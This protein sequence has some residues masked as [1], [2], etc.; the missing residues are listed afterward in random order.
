MNTY[1]EYALKVAGNKRINETYMRYI[2][3]Y[4]MYKY[5][6][7]NTTKIGN[8]KKYI[9]DSLGTPLNGP[10]TMHGYPNGGY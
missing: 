6:V 8:I 9:N 1:G 4:T 2:G 10:F 7:L 3:K 5:A